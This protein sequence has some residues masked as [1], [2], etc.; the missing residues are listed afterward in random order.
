M[1]SEYGFSDIVILNA[2]LQTTL[3]ISR[4]ART[5]GDAEARAFAAKLETA[6]RNLLPRFDKGC[7]SLYSLG[8]GNASRHTTGT[9]SGSLASSPRRTGWAVAR[10]VP[11]L[12]GFVLM[13]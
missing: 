13:G 1:G 2:Q 3:N 8:G 11:P 12:A 4:F 9:T 6:S 7:W 10:S 5:S